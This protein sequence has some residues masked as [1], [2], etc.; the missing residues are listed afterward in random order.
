MLRTL[1]RVAV[2]PR[3]ALQH[4][5][6]EDAPQVAR[7]GR[8]NAVAFDGRL[9]EDPRVRE[10]RNANELVQSEILGE[11]ER[12]AS[13]P[14]SLKESLGLSG[15][16]S[17]QFVLGRRIVSL[18]PLPDPSLHFVQGPEL[19]GFEPLLYSL[20]KWREILERG[21]LAHVPF[22]PE[23]ESFAVPPDGRRSLTEPAPML[24]GKRG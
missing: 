12:P 10:R 5:R 21:A 17:G 9:E 24:V 6:D 15:A 22:V 18:R 2:G 8:G 7:L 4:L 23:D 19:T 13:L 11:V 16:Q 14:V 1:L 3:H 20:E